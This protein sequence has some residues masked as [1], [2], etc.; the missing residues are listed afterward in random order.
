[1]IKTNKSIN[2][3]WIHPFNAENL[4]PASYDLTLSEEY[5]I[6][7]KKDSSMTLI[8]KPHSFILAASKERVELPSNVAADVK[9]RSSFGRKGIYVFNGYIDPG[10]CGNVTVGL[11]NASDETISIDAGTRFCQLVFYDTE[12]EARKYNGKYQNSNGVTE[13]VDDSEVPLC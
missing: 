6:R 9:G 4:Q 8:L 12:T 13:S 11:Y 7:D 5:I 2:P 3:E 1:M 10:F